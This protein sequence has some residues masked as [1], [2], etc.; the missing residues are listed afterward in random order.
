VDVKAAFQEIFDLKDK[1]NLLEQKGYSLAV[2]FFRLPL[3]DEEKDPEKSFTTAMRCVS[4]KHG[5]LN[6]LAQRSCKRLGD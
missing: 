2:H 6:Y 5:H 3:S 1:V 4:F